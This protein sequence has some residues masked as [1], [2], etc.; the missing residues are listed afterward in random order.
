[1]HIFKITHHFLVLY[2]L[3]ARFQTFLQSLKMV[4]FNSF[5][6]LFEDISKLKQP[7]HLDQLMQKHR[8]ANLLK[9]PTFY[10][11]ILPFFKKKTCSTCLLFYGWRL[12]STQKTIR[13]TQK[14]KTKELISSRQYQPNATFI[15]VSILTPTPFLNINCFL[16]KCPTCAFMFA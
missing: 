1:M 10:S 15:L 13:N 7:F 14:M 9:N 3:T 5:A 4:L 12:G 11:E 2:T 8:V 6:R 16:L